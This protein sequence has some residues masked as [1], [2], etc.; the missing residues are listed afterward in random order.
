ME[1][2]TRN[3]NSYK[4]TVA[5][6]DSDDISMLNNLRKLVSIANKKRCSGT[7]ALRVRVALRKPKQKM[8][9]YDYG[10]D[11]GGNVIGGIK[12]AQEADVYVYEVY[13]TKRY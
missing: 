10:Y 1:F 9:G 2:K 8:L 7:N 13:G 6:D 4:F 3:S 11:Y 5:L 12:N